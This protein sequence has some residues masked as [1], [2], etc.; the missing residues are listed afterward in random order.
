MGKLTLSSVVIVTALLAFGFG[1]LADNYSL[2]QHLASRLEG[3]LGFTGSNSSVP[4]DL[5]YTSV[6]ELYDRLR[7]SYE[8]ELSE[9]DL[10]DGLKRGL[11]AATGDPYTVYLSPE[12]A[13][14]FSQ[15]LNNEFS[16]IGA[17]I[18]IKNGQLQVITPI[19]GTPADRAGLRPGEPIFAIDG[20]D[21]TGMF[22]DEAVSKIRGP[23]NTQVVLTIGRDG[24]AQDVTI[25]RAKIEIANVEGRILDGN[26]GY[27]KINTFGEKSVSEA[28]A[29][30][31]W[32]KDSRVSAVIV[33]LRG[34][35]GGLLESS[36]DIAGLWLDNSVVVEQRGKDSAVL[37]SRGKGVLRGVKTIALV[38]GG[39]AS[40]SEIVAG[41][42]KDNGAAVLV[43]ETTFGKGSVQTLES[44]QAGAQLKVT[45]ARWFTPKG[46]NIDKEGIKPDIE[47]KLT[48]EDFD[49]SRDP[50][51]AKALEL[52]R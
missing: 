46:Q 17:E 5:D 31:R 43:G 44:L 22:I 28:T 8:G 13:K 42:L 47:V 45:I 33:D 35:G 30:A 3:A 52:L 12:E 14:Q 49:N 9:K 26:I 20:E 40:A 10:L 15:T 11:A 19:S 51:L 16:G 1:L 36:I 24:K 18:G 29:L 27:M 4:D 21:T 41:A 32:F 50:Q 48:S 38:N 6:E 2:G 25:V 23:E 7:T 37:R 34:N 39:S